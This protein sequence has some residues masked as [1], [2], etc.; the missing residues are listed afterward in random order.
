[1]THMLYKIIG[2][3]I[4]YKKL[5]I[6]AIQ[7]NSNN[8]FIQKNDSHGIQN[9]WNNNFISKMTHMPSKIIGITISYKKIKLMLYKIIGLTIRVE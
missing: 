1:M 4:S 7:N 5:L 3:T 6:Y 9:N 2:I 8:N